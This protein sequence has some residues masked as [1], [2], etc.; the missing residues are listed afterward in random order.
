[1]NPPHTNRCVLSGL[2]TDLS[3]PLGKLSQPS[4]LLP[5]AHG[6]ALNVVTQ[7]VH[8]RPGS[9]SSLSQLEA[10]WLRDRLSQVQQHRRVWWPL[11]M[12][13]VSGSRS[14]SGT[15]SRREGKRSKRRDSAML[16]SARASGAP[17]QKCTPYPEATCCLSGRVASNTAAVSPCVRGLL[18]AAPNDARIAS[19]WRIGV[20]SGSRMSV[21]A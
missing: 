14:D 12:M 7:S 21:T 5:I 10:G 1:M 20:P 6:C 4:N 16:A 9:W 15:A 18:L 19:P 3:H 13:L 2:L 17:R 8:H 11:P